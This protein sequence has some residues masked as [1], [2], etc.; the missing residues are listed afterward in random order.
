MT[1]GGHQE[2]C[3]IW[4]HGVLPP[5]LRAPT[6]MPCRPG[7]LVRLSSLTLRRDRLHT[8]DTDIAVAQNFIDGQIINALAPRSRHPR[9]TA[10]YVMSFPCASRPRVLRTTVRD[11]RLSRKRTRRAQ[12]KKGTF[13]LTGTIKFAEVLRC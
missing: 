4:E 1:D 13:I 6:P 8:G 12:L 10:R 11:T 9:R 7:R 2:P 3:I 5:Q